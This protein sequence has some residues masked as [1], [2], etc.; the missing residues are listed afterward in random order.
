MTARASKRLLSPGTTLGRYTIVRAIGRGGMGAVYEATHN[1]LRKRVALKALDPKFANHPEV[2]QRFRKEGESAAQIRHP[3]VI[4]IYDVGL[5]GD[6]PYLV[7]ELMVGEDL[8]IMLERTGAMSTQAAV[9]LM[10]PV[11]AGLAAAHRGNVIHRD[12]KPG[13]IFLAQNELG[14]VVP[15]VFDFGI[16]KMTDA[17]VDN[18]T[19][20]GALLGTPIYMSPEQARA[21]GPVDRRADIYAFGVVL[22]Q[23]LTGERPFAGRSTYQVLSSIVNGQFDPPRKLVPSLDPQL[24]A[25]VLRAMARAPAERFTS[26]PD[27]GAALLPFASSHQQAVWAPVFGASDAGVEH[28]GADTNEAA[29]AELSASA[30]GSLSAAGPAAQRSVSSSGP[31]M[32]ADASTSGS[33]SAPSASGSL[34]APS[35]SGS[36]MAADASASGSLSAPS[37]NVSG[38]RIPSGIQEAALIE[39]DA[40]YAN[41]PTLGGIS[42]A[43]EATDGGG[44]SLRWLWLVM[45]LLGV[46][47]AVMGSVV[48]WSEQPVPADKVTVV[49]PPEPPPEPPAE[50]PPPVPMPKPAMFTVDLTVEP[51]YAQ[52]LID[53]DV[54][55]RGHYKAELLRNGKS[56]ALTVRARGY[57]RHESVFTDTSPPAKIALHRL[58]MRRAKPVSIRQNPFL[59]VETSSA[60]GAR[61]AKGVATSS[62]SARLARRGRK[63][64]TTSTRTARRAPARSRRSPQ[65]PPPSPAAPP[66]S[67][68]V[69]IEPTP[70]LPAQWLEDA[71][72]TS[73]TS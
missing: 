70:D 10:L 17:P 26:M 25:I 46:F 66:P 58:R 28:A 47:L 56:H 39:P 38:S 15:K 32:A 19:T 49:V 43:E 50:A 9:D 44:Q 71:V 2:S 62:T 4:D 3:N 37:A 52:I 73:S 20:P 27:L 22:Y 16:S 29:L 30:S 8:G 7:M 5:E 64:T 13:N 42:E 61:R 35:S 54:V 60:S 67:P 24:E 33:L 59:S 6:I 34:S 45:A 68:T 69:T 72:E 11:C 55:G 40:A 53:G 65:P 23:C 41:A 21:R 36:L 14:T 18:L 63:T 57:R 1:V 51:S 12:L 31:L 48:M